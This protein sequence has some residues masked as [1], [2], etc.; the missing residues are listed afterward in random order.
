MI[1]VL[2]WILTLAIVVAVLAV[3]A[4]I[5]EWWKWRNERRS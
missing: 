1:R 5:S 4:W 2:W 3:S